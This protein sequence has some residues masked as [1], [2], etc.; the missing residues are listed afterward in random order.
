MIHTG[1]ETMLFCAVLHELPDYRGA[2]DL[3]G[4]AGVRRIIVCDYDP[5]LNG[6]LRVWMN[7]FEPDAVGWWGCQLR[8]LLPESQWSL[9]RGRITRSLVWWE[10]SRAGD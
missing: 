2:L 3:A 10:F 8:L 7:N 1:Y 5:E 6:W 4:G 9:R